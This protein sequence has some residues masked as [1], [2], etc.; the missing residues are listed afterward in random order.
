MPG[1]TPGAARL[2]LAGTA[3]DAFGT[4][5]TVPLLLALRAAATRTRRPRRLMAS[6]SR[7]MQRSLAYA[8]PSSIVAPPHDSLGTGDGGVSSVRRDR[9]LERTVRRA[10]G[11]S[12][13]P[14]ARAGHT[15]A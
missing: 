6:V 4:G 8:A 9:P 3:V 5:L 12:R 1:R 10:N 15:R 2:L 11:R 7:S 14:T 13:S